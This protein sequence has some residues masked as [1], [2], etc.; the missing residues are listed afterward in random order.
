M[1]K[2][3]LEMLWEEEKSGKLKAIVAQAADFYRPGANNSVLNELVI[4]RMKTGKNPQW[5]YSGEKKNSF[6]SIPDSG[7]RLE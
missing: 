1:R 5:L 4:N 6:T 2:R 7:K 3:I